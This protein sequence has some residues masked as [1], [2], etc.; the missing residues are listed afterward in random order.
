LKLWP[1]FSA[2]PFGMLPTV[3]PS[4]R[5]CMF[6]HIPDHSISI[7]FGPP[8]VSEKV[9]FGTRPGYQGTTSDA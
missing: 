3:W 2:L 8:G 7:R 5:T 4:A 9:F 6:F 1:A